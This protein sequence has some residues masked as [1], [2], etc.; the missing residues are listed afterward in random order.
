MGITKD[1]VSGVWVG[2]EDRS[3]HF[4][5]SSTGEG[6]KTALPIFGLF[7]EKLYKEKDLGYKMGRFPK[8]V[9]KIRKD[10]YCPTPRYSAP[11]SDSVSTDDLLERLN[12]SLPT[13][14]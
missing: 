2:G 3:I 10:Y 7:M 1:L 5:T 12:D 8:P 14:I 11:K 13:G 9:V 6:S 4:R